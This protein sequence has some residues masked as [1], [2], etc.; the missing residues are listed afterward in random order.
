[1][2]PEEIEFRHG[3]G[4]VEQGKFEEG[5]DVLISIVRPL[6]HIPPAMLEMLLPLI[7]K[8]DSPFV[9]WM[10]SSEGNAW[11]NG[12]SQRKPS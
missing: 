7:S 8:N 4:L 10:L 6:E 5:S 11:M 3:C 12:Y 1:M 9:V 2:T